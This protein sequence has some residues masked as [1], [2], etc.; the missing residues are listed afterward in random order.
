MKLTASFMHQ[1][2]QKTTVNVAC[3]TQPHTECEVTECQALLRFTGVGAAAAAAAA[4][5][6][7]TLLLTLLAE[8]AVCSCTPADASCTE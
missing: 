8:G 7:P 6:Q 2:L 1:L 4:V 5:V 3:V